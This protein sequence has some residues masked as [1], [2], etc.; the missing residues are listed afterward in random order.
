M[1]C[2]LTCTVTKFIMGAGSHWQ[3]VSW[4]GRLGLHH[5]NIRVHTNPERALHEDPFLETYE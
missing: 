4:R 1:D 2:K 3:I 5:S